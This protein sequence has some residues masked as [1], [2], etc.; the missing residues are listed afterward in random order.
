MYTCYRIIVT[1]LVVCVE[2][3]KYNVFC[4]L[5]MKF[6]CF[7]LAITIVIL[8]ISC[9]HQQSFCHLWSSIEQWHITNGGICAEQTFLEIGMEISALYNSNS[10]LLLTTVEW[11]GDRE[12]IRVRESQHGIKPGTFS[13]K[14]LEVAVL[15]VLGQTWLSICPYYWCQ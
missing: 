5:C 12:R 8:H 10:F 2:W 1:E 3:T 14:R 11:W 15:T 13:T 7:F 9:I 6:V 4:K